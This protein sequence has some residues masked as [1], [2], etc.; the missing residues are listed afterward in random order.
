MIKLIIY[1]SVLLVTVKLSGAQQSSVDSLH[2]AIAT[3]QNDTLK[4]ILFGRLTNEFTEIS[5]DSAYYYSEKWAT[6]AKKLDYQLEQ[7]SALA[8]MGY[9][10]IN[11]G[12]Y[13]RSLQTFLSA[14]SIANNPKSEKK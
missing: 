10:L 2:G 6:L 9:A 7:T 4:L 14:L 12:N 1:T 11:L 13:P 8:Q 5:P 3:T